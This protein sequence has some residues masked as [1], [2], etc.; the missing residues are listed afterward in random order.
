MNLNQKRVFVGNPFAGYNVGVKEFVTSQPKY[1]LG[2][3]Y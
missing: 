1:G 2:I 3:I